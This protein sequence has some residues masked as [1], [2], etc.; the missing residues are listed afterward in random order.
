ME[1][2]E[3]S[4][5]NNPVITY[6]P[7]C[8][9]WTEIKLNRNREHQK[10]VEEALSEL[11]HITKIIKKT[12]GYSLPFNEYKLATHLTEILTE[13][14]RHAEMLEEQLRE[15]DSNEEYNKAINYLVK[16]GHEPK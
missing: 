6:K 9:D 3:E 15:F 16:N 5:V 14:K 13:L 4:P 1:N 7:F 2:K 8:R 11:N 12:G 10:V